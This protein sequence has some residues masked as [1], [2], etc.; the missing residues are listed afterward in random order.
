MEK[1]NNNRL[2]MLALGVLPGAGPARLKDL[3]E[4]LRIEGLTWDDLPS[5]KPEKIRRLSLSLPMQK[6]IEKLPLALEEANALQEKMTAQGIGWLSWDDELYPPRLRQFISP[7]PPFLLFYSGNP[8]LLK[9]RHII[10]IIGTRRPTASGIKAAQMA[11]E[12]T[13]K[14]KV[15]VASGGANGIDEAAHKSALQ[16]GASIFVLPWGLFYLERMKRFSYLLNGLNHLFLSEFH[17]RDRGTRITPIQRNRTVAA[18]SDALLAV[19]TGAVGGTLHT[20]RFA[21]GFKKPILAVDYSP[22]KNPAGNA[23]LLSTV[24]QKIPA[25]KLDDKIAWDIL[26]NALKRGAALALRKPPEQATLF[27]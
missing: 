21:R 3:W 14:R 6:A 27:P 19:E 12:A 11:A 9:S 8:D 22:E 1:H 13:A 17:P 26:R 4:S 23:S 7:A 18:L 16:F 25:S 20:V 5:L 15:A 2:L 10:G 24:A